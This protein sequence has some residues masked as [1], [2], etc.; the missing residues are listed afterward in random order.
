MAQLA[1]E[2]AATN[3]HGILSRARAAQLIRDA[4]DEPS[5]PRTGATSGRVPPPG[6]G[7]V[8]IDAIIHITDPSPRVVYVPVPWRPR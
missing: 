3:P 4:L 7:G 1:D 6:Q 2:L 5:P 8:V